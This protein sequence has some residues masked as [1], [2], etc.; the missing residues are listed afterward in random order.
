MDPPCLDWIT[1]L[2]GWQQQSR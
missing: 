2:L 1:S